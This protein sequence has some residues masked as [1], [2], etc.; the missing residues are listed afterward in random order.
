MHPAV[1]AAFEE[2]CRDEEIGCAILEVGA[3]PASDTLLRLPSLRSARR[4][5]GINLEPAFR[6]DAIEILSGTANRM[7]QF[8]AA[9][10]DAV[11][12]NATLEHDPLF[13]LTLAEMRRVLRPGGLLA[14]G[15]PGFG[16]MKTL[17]FWRAVARASRVPV[18][19]RPLRSMARWIGA[20]A[21]TLGV[22]RYPE[23]YYRFSEAAVRNVFLAGLVEPRVKTLLM[24]PRLIGWG[25]S[26]R[27]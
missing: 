22:H 7:E 14:I 4:R 5:I 27:P 6:D 15:V 20:A 26:V 25:R 21:P 10:F 19:G 11:L 2:L 1:F 12:C 13:W 8:D 24:P 23:D 16:A 17:P 18:A 9:T 3:V